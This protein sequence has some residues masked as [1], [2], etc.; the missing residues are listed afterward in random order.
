MKIGFIGTGVMGAPMATHLSRH[1]QVTVYNR[2]LHKAQ[3]VQGQIVVA[4]TL[5]NRIFNNEVI[6]TMVGNP[7]DVENIYTQLLN[8]CAPNTYLIDF[9]TSS[10]LLAKKLYFLGQTK[11]IHILDAPVT[12]GEKGAINQSLSIMVGGEE[13]VYQTLLPLLKLVG[14]NVLY[15]GGPGQGQHAKMANQIAI[16]GTLA[17]LAEALVYAQKQQLNLTQ[18]LSYLTKGA[19]SSYSAIH[20][21]EKMIN[22][23]WQA[24]FYLK[25]YL[26]DL[27]I[28]LEVY[29]DLPVVAYVKS[30]LEKLVLNYGEKGVQSIIQAYLNQ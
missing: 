17:S 1:H 16:A 28:A 30:L 23:D 14:N 20:Y 4:E 26:K 29:P 21:G 18:V 7:A 15:M 6:M 5:D 27:T 13:S 12:G 2:S 24:S 3:N 25:H 9:T 19:A 8:H 22:H 10:P 11:G